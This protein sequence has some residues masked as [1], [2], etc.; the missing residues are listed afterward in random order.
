ML[1]ISDAIFGKSKAAAIASVIIGRAASIGQIIANTG[2]ANAKA[3]AASPLTAGQP[4]VTINTISSA[5]SIGSSVA[6]GAKA[7]SEINAQKA[8]KG[9]TL[10]GSSHANGGIG[11]FDEHGN[12]VVEAEGKKL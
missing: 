10:Q 12:K 1:T 7:I 3:I 11:L 6:S 8:A 4:F 5:L 9:I 2:I